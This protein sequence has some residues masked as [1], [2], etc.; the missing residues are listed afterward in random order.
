MNWLEINVGF[1]Q[2][3][4]FFFKEINQNSLTFAKDLY[5]LSLFPFFWKKQL[6][7]VGVF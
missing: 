2:K 7:F 4:S 5:F 6:W 1:F 3:V